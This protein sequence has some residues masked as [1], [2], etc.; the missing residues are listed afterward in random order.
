MRVPILSKPISAIRRRIDLVKI[1]A[2]TKRFIAHNR[3]VWRTWKVS[4]PE[5]VVLCWYTFG[6]HQIVACSYPLNVLA[7]KHSATIKAFSNTRKPFPRSIYHRETD[8]LFRSFNVADIARVTLSDD[9]ERRKEQVSHQIIPTI[10]TKQDLYDLQVMDTWIGIDIYETYLKY[11]NRPTADLD[12]PRLIGLVDEAI[13]LLIYWQ[14]YF[15]ATNVAA[16]VLDADTYIYQNILAKVAY[17]RDVPVYLPGLM[18]IVRA[19]MPHPRYVAL[20]DSYRGLFEKLSPAEKSEGLA[21]AE[22]QLGRRLKGDLSVDQYTPR[23]A[24]AAPASRS[25]V[26]KSG[27]KIKILI[28]SHCFYDNP[29]AYGDSLFVDFYEWLQFLGRTS[30]NTDY[31]WYIKMHPEPLPGTEEIIRGIIQ[32]FPRITFLPPDTSFRQLVDEGVTVALTVFGSVGH[33]LPALGVQVIN[34]GYNPRAAYDFNLHPASVEEYE[35][36]LL[37]LDQLQKTTNMDDLYEFYYVHHYY[38]RADDLFLPSF[39]RFRSEVD[40]GEQATSA[41]Y[42]YFLDRLYEEKHQ[43]LVDR[44]TEFIDSEEQALFS[45]GP[46]SW[47]TDNAQSA[48]G[49]ELETRVAA[50]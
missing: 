5:S 50:E 26:L 3:K 10:R 7:R 49:S 34:A 24:Y 11:F 19:D 44:I 13:G 12:N 6:V 20:F 14:D 15:D 41:F 39:N 31:D 22:I 28:C 1:D 37:N 17:T 32:E 42:G 33:E 47:R 18:E 30:E 45:R 43:Q 25:R 29:H 48:T 2:D 35:S 9:Q 36:L 40:R 27:D 8:E 21:L 16:V 4:R 23:S 38:V 46:E